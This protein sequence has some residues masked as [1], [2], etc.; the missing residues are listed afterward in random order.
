MFYD[1]ITHSDDI[2]DFVM[3]Q[4]HPLKMIS[5]DEELKRLRKAQNGYDSNGNMWISPRRVWF[6]DM[7][8]VRS[9]LKEL[10]RQVRIIRN[11][12][13]IDAS[14]LLF[15]RRD[16]EPH[17]H[18]EMFNAF[19]KNYTVNQIFGDVQLSIIKRNRY[20]S[21]FENG[22]IIAARN[23]LLFKEKLI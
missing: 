12:L 21:N 22:A 14:V 4:I 23:N 19:P 8:E 10:V 15:D 2:V 17:T 6:E 11:D 9:G 16:N 20:V 5:S 1:D 3:R 18:F 13:R 7:D